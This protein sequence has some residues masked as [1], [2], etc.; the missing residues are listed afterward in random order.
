MAKPKITTIPATL[1]AQRMNIFEPAQKRRTA[2]YARV[3]TDQEEQ[4]TS[5]TA[6]VDFYTKKI[7][8]NPDW[9][10]VGVYTDEGISAVNTK[11]R[12]GFNNMIADALAGNIDLIVTKSV[13]RFARNTVDSLSTIRKLK[14]HGTEVY[15][16]KESIWTFDGKGELL[17]TIMSSLAQEESRSISEN[18]SWGKRR[19]FEQ[20]NVY[21]PYARFLGYERGEDGRPKIIESE[22]KI[23]R[24]IY[25]AFLHGMTTGAIAKDLNRRGIPTPSG[26]GTW[27]VSTVTS[28]LQNEKYKGEALLQKTVGIDFLQKTR[29]TNEGEAP[30]YHVLESHEPIVASEVFDLVQEEFTKRRNSGKVTSC[31]HPFSS[32]VICGECGGVFGTKTWRAR[33]GGEVYGRQVWQCN[34]KYRVKG[35]VNCKTPHLT[36]VQLEY[37]FLTAFNQILGNKEQ[38]IADYEP[39]IAMLTDCTAL[40]KQTSELTGEQEELYMLVKNCIDEKAR[41]GGN[42]ALADRYNKLIGKYDAIKQWLDDIALE[43]QEQ[44]IKRTKIEAFLAELKTQGDII[45]EFDEKLWQRTA[46]RIIVC[47]ES[48]VVVEFKDGRQIKVS[49]IGK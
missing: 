24:D 9:E 30:Q 31:V 41:H 48:E 37:A 12:E 40:E 1:T 3:S 14:E 11:R 25:S 26:K 38:Y 16:E 17:I 2:A 42:E 44:Q 49:V 4:E 8:E 34:E 5:F 7:K 29:K 47:R 10:F 46:E 43:I 13:S 22:A 35:K 20:G 28:I 23:I 18:V 33:Q 21:L 45:T 15:F 19:S 27:S 39:I 32:R 36:S 6:Q